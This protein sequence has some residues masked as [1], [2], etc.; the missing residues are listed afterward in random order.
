MTDTDLATRYRAYI[1][2]L[3]RQDWSSLGEYVSDDV[4]HNG[5]PLGLAGYRAMLEQDFRDIPDLRFDIRLLVC[6]PP[7]VACRLRFACA[8]KGTFMGLAVDGRKVTFAENVFYEFH[9]GKIRQVWSVIDKAAIEQ[10]L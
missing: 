3:N 7:H 2:C 4:I 8:P 9:E 10:Q 5:R 6:E 1:D